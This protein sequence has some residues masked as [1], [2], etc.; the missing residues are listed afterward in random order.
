[1]SEKTYNECE[2]YLFL[3]SVCSYL[4]VL[5]CACIMYVARPKGG[6]FA[7]KSNR[8]LVVDACG[9][10]LLEG[11]CRCHVHTGVICASTGLSSESFTPMYGLET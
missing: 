11:V 3:S 7:L 4:C 10:I 5:V 6:T 1:M 2:G 8:Y 9:V